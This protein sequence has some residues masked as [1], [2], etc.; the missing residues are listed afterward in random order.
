MKKLVAILAVSTLL[1]TGNISYALGT[2]AADKPVKNVQSAQAGNDNKAKQAA[3][4]EILK[5]KIFPKRQ[6]IIEKKAE[7]R[8]TFLTVK[9]HI[10]ELRENKD[11][12]DTEQLESLK[13]AL[14]TIK[15]DRLLL[16]NA[17]ADC[18]KEIHALRMAKKNGDIDKIEDIFENNISTLQ[19]EIED[20]LQKIEDDL[21]RIAKL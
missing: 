20:N 6:E 5:Q 16:N 19:D 9:N 4:K 11:N 13:D 10:K 18:A 3:V 17:I 2:Q 15:D 1:I 21:N 14:Q 7:L 12:L 8:Q